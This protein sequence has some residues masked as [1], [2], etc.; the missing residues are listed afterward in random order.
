M[1]RVAITT[2]FIMEI[3]F[4]HFQSVEVIKTTTQDLLQEY[5][6]PKE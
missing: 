1:L 2:V 5:D 3:I 6:K 4:E